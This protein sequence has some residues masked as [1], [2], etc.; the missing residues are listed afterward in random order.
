MKQ[1]EPHSSSEVALVGL[2]IGAILALQAAAAIGG[3]TSSRA[4]ESLPFRPSL[5]S[6]AQGLCATDSG[7]LRATKSM[8]SRHPRCRPCPPEPV[9]SAL[10]Q[11]N[12]DSLPTAPAFKSFWSSTTIV[13]LIP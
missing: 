4:V 13:L 8:S 10:E 2:R 3:V 5:R 11:L 9:A 6:R 7:E 1:R 12:L